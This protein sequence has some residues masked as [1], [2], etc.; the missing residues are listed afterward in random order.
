MLSQIEAARQRLQAIEQEAEILRHFLVAWEAAAPLLDA[1][2]PSQTGGLFDVGR[3]VGESAN[4]VSQEGNAQPLSPPKRSRVTDN[5][6]KEVLIPAAIEIIRG[7]GRPLSRRALH[8]ALAARGL[9]VKGA[10]PI[11]ALGT[12]LWRAPD[13]LVQLE[14]FGYWPKVD[15]YEP[16]N[17][18]GPQGDHPSHPTDRKFGN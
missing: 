15:P 12:I 4:S 1:P 13:D 11:K 2:A 3:A 5:P 8:E 6:K 14:G 17:Y 18:A 10:D 9:V 7:H 16:A